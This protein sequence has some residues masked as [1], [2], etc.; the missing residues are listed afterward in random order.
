MWLARQFN[1]LLRWLQSLFTW[2]RR[3]RLPLATFYTSAQ[4]HI[5]QNSQGDRTQMIAKMSGGTAITNVENLIQHF[6]LS[7]EEILSL[8][9]FWQ[10]WSQDTN[11]PLSSSLVI[12]GREQECDR[13]IGWLRDSS[14]ALITG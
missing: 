14:S 8:E 1:C 6:H 10:N 11:P 7:P 3:M 5:Q 12:G 4:T 9:S 13:S 2:K